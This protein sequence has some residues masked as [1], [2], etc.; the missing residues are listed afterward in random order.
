M[1]PQT[2]KSRGNIENN[3]SAVKLHEIGP[4]LTI[5]LS[6]IEDGLFNGEVLYHRRVIKTEEEL[7]AIAAEREQK[8][9]TK[10]AR[11]KQQEENA[12]GKELAKDEHKK[13]SM[14]GG[15]ERFDRNETVASDD[16]DAAYYEQEVGQKPDEELFT[17]A[18]SSGRKRGY[19]PKYMAGRDAAKRRRTDTKEADGPAKKP[20]NGYKGRK[21]DPHK[22]QG[23]RNSDRL[24]ER[25]LKRRPG[26]KSSKS[27]GGGKPKAG[28][29]S[30]PKK[31]THRK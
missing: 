18:Q 12:A 31:R 26:G 25:D 3:K 4:R 27:G 1:L 30:K 28:G 19:T 22:A 2:L 16:D 21:Y 6:K 5:E 13:K 17:M 23:N 15:G 11:R 7:V 20:L 24:D 10:A 29:S 8:R 14:R 9:R